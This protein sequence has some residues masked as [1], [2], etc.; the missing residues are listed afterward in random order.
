MPS[1]KHH[2]TLDDIKRHVV[3]SKDIHAAPTRLICLENTLGGTILPLSELK[4][5]SAFARENDIKLHLDGARLWN[6][7]AAG[8]GSLTDYTTLFD[9]VSLC[10]SKGLGA[11]AGSILVGKQDF[12]DHGRHV[13]KSIGGG[14]RQ[15]GVL[16]SAARV[17]V[18]EQF[19][20]GVNGEGGKLQGTHQLAKKIANAWTTMGGK[21]QFETETNMVWLDLDDAG[22][23]GEEFVQLGKDHGL[24]LL[25][26]RLV[27]HYQ[28]GREAI[29]NLGKVMDE[30]LR[31]KGGENVVPFDG[32]V[33]KRAYG[34][35]LMD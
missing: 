6:A 12:I 24:K 27:V 7:V 2:L 15:V 28:I 34:S 4:L 16:T 19:G 8:A 3:I 32:K 26:G 35:Y 9:S 30:V 31:R 22:I 20:L 23:T 14:L 1:N 5:I 17:A 18:D 25:S 10:F 21:L 11:P 13:R 29:E 33:K